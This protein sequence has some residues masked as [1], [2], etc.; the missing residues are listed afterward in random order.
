[1]SKFSID[2]KKEGSSLQLLNLVQILKKI[3]SSNKF[4]TFFC[5]LE[6][7]T[8]LWTKIHK[9]NTSNNNLKKQE[10]SFTYEYFF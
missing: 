2:Q 5:K 6:A 4:F 8:L 3:F 10:V 7:S 9:V 1:M